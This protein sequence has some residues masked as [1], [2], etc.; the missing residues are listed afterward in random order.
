MINQNL[1]LFLFTCRLQ[2][3]IHQIRM[4]PEDKRGKRTK[5]KYIYFY[6]PTFQEKLHNLSKHWV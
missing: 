3:S 5:I 1:A 6:F 4:G 2:A